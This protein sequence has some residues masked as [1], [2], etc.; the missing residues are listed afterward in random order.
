MVKKNPSET[1]VV[2]IAKVADIAVLDY[3][4]EETSLTDK[5]GNS[6]ESKKGYRCLLTVSDGQIVYKD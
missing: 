5:S 6:I 3:S 4:D 1:F 2:H